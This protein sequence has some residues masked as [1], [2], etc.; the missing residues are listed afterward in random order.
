MESVKEK[1]GFE[2]KNT[3]LNITVEDMFEFTKHELSRWMN[4]PINE[5]ERH[6]AYYA[7][8]KRLQLFLLKRGEELANKHLEPAKIAELTS[9]KLRSLPQKA[10][11]KN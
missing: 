11:I 2:R 9:L 10:E 1:A 6:P 4:I 8:R 3:K 7:F 5:I